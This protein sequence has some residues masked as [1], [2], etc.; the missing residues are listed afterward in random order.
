MASS[1]DFVQ[2]IAE[3]IKG[4]GEIRYKLMFGEYGIYCNEKIVALVCDNRLFIKPT[5]AGRQFIDNVIEAPPYPGAKMSFLIEE[6][7]DDAKWL[8]ELV[9][10]TDKELPP[11]KPK[12]K[13]GSQKK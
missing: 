10:V 6:K 1:L 8:T 12:K 5:D 11:P 7:I 9:K 3:Q 2:F 13:K 4:A